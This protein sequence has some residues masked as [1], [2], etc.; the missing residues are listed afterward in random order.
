MGIQF[1]EKLRPLVS[2]LQRKIDFPADQPFFEMVVI[3]TGQKLR[4][5]AWTVEYRITQQ[6]LTSRENFL[7][8]ADTAARF[9]QIYPPEK[10]ALKR[11]S[12]Q[13]FPAMPGDQHCKRCSREMIHGFRRSGRTPS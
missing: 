10:H 11:S 1:L 6:L 8:D 7:A 3:D 9:T 5:E 13:C 4:A 12:K 2:Q